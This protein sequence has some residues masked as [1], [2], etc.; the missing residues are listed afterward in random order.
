MRG[1]YLV[2]VF[3]ARKPFNVHYD[4]LGWMHISM[5]TSDGRLF[6]GVLDASCFTSAFR[7]TKL[8]HGDGFRPADASASAQNG[9][10][11]TDRTE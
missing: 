3:T 9:S 8:Q 4:R 5:T 1:F 10:F 11:F 2:R 6:A 7:N